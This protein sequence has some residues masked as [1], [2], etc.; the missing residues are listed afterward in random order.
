MA[1]PF[2]GYS[3]FDSL[4]RESIS[5]QK[6]MER[7]RSLQGSTGNV[8]TAQGEIYGVSAKRAQEIASG[9]A[10]YTS[11]GA[12]SAFGTGA[13]RPTGESY[14]AFMN[15]SAGSFAIGSGEVVNVA[16]NPELRGVK[17]I[18]AVSNAEAA[19]KANFGSV[20]LSKYGRLGKIGQ[21]II[22]SVTSAPFIGNLFGGNMTVDPY[23]KETY[24]PLGIL[25]AVARQ[26]IQ[27]QY[28]VAEKIKQGLP[29]YHQFYSGNQL[30]SLVPQTVFGKEVGYAVLGSP[31]LTSE[32]AIGQY[33][34]M[35]GYDP[36]SLDLT[37]RPGERGFGTELGGFIPGV[38]GVSNTG[39]FVD[40]YGSRSSQPRDVPAYLG[41]MSD[42]YGVEYASNQ[43]RQM[44]L[45]ESTLQGLR[46]GA[47]APKTYRDSTG[48][49]V[50]YGT[51]TGGMVTDADGNPV[52]GGSGYVSYGSGYMSTDSYDAIKD[53]ART[54]QTYGTKVGSQQTQMLADQD[55]EFNDE[56]DQRDA[57][58]AYG[59]DREDDL[60]P[61]ASGGFV[62]R[63]KMQEGG[64]AQVAEGAA[65]VGDTP[66]NIPNVQTVADDVEVDVP[67]GSFVLNAAA[68]EYMGSADVKKMILE[69]I[70]EAEK[71]GIDIKQENSK[72]PREDL[73]SLA[74]S[75]GEVI[76]PPQLAEIIGY[77]RLT[78]IN[79]RG[80]AE[81]Q[82]RQEEAEQQK[83]APAPT[84]PPGII[85]ASTGGFIGNFD[86]RE[87]ELTYSRAVLEA[88]EGTSDTPHVPSDNSG[89][90]IGTGFDLGQHSEFDLKERYGFGD[91]FIEKVRPF[92][93]TGQGQRG[94]LGKEAELLYQNSGIDFSEDARV[95]SQQ[96][97]SQKYDE[98][99]KS[100]PQFKDALPKDKAALFSMY[101]VGGL[102]RYKTLQRVYEETGDIPQAI[103]KGLLRKIPKGSPEYNRAVNL[104]TFYY[105]ADDADVL[106]ENPTAIEQQRYALDMLRTQRK[107]RSRDRK[108]RKEGSFID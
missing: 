14:S 95:A 47:Y 58:E 67:E 61:F 87:E 35:Y 70:K 4:M 62:E 91:E 98:F 63:K 65:V 10:T 84:E 55:R 43:A 37:K 74:A 46:T 57:A 32:Q 50:G 22:N 69:A 38:G 75:R 101:Y 73:V 60:D 5:R 64:E 90:T 96:I 80:K 105:T 79:N 6:A 3:I 9:T 107:G 76:V 56:D 97:L 48:Q 25:G 49:T 30:V 31:D 78:K 85:K 45:D 66:E 11:P 108:I 24:V 16:E 42:I 12:V 40:S 100:Y 26:N 7:Y 71:Q 52:K 72:I 77:D 29:G 2:K 33:A 34:A 28:E 20:G 18:E 44:G 82:R 8:P 15:A 86:P 21:T 59:R 93:A 106:E 94:P 19:A 102:D 68:V 103:D 17:G 92:L 54:A 53:S 36:E 89:L 1:G 81:V 39:E 104:L 99:E 88:V 41:M 83:Q 13:A 23:G 27:K 51:G